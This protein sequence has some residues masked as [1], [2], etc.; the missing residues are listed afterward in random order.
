MSTSIPD[1]G[2]W[3]GMCSRARSRSPC[4]PEGSEPPVELTT[5]GVGTSP[6]PWGSMEAFWYVCSP[7]P[8]L[9]DE[10]HGVV[11]LLVGKYVRNP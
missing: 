11:T 1:P 8:S 5:K 2:R 4:G 3:A 6:G 7:A 9:D 10:G